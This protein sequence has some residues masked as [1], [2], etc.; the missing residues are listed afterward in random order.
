MTWLRRGCGADHAEVGHARLE[1][2]AWQGVRSRSKFLLVLLLLLLL[3]LLL[4][5]LLLPLL[6]LL[7]II[8][9]TAIVSEDGRATVH[10]RCQAAQ[11]DPSGRVLGKRAHS[12][13]HL[14]I[15]SDPCVSSSSTY[16]C[17]SNA[18]RTGSK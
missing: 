11:M 14:G 4:L 2:E 9:M 6:L 13:P 1:E 8:I 3:F 7:I 16:F 17:D 15:S 18:A 12:S 10:P 5:L